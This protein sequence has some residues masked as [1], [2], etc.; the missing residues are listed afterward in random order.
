MR[1]ELLEQFDVLVRTHFDY[2]INSRRFGPFE[3]RRCAVN[4]TAGLEPGTSPERRTICQG[5]TPILTDVGGG[6]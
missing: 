6:N 2:D 4:V 5:R 3:V 1:S